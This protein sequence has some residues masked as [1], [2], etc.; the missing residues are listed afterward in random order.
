M[1]FQ[2]IALP[3]ELLCSRCSIRRRCHGLKIQASTNRAEDFRPDGGI[4][5]MR[6]GAVWLNLCHPSA[7]I[8]RSC[9]SRRS[10]SAA[11]QRSGAK[12]A[13][14]GSGTNV[15]NT[16]DEASGAPKLEARRLKSRAF[17]FSVVIEIPLE[18]VFARL[19]KVG[20]HRGEVGCV[21]RLVEIGVAGQGVTNDDRGLVDRLS[22]D[23]TNRGY[24]TLRRSPARSCESWWNPRRPLRRGNL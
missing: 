12:S 6:N 10:P 7:A 2:S 18:P 9:N 17:T 21:N 11:E 13:H 3:S 5:K 22:G 23:R 8:T 20:S 19:I 15:P 4:C 16:G 24:S 14:A 1:D